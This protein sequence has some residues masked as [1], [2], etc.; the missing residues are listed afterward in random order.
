[1]SGLR[2]VVCIVVDHE[3]GTEAVTVLGGLAV[4][5]VHIPVV[6]SDGLLTAVRGVAAAARGDDG[7]WG[8]AQ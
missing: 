5:A 4:C 7:P 2:C 3:A 6:P 1:V 8:A